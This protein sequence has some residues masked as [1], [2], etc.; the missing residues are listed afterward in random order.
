MNILAEIAEAL[1]IGI[2]LCADCFAVS[3]CASLGM[4]RQQLRSS[5]WKVAPSF[6]VIQSLLLV[7]GWLAAHLAGEWMAA[8]LAHYETIAHIIA[9]LL[10]LWIGLEMVIDSLRKEETTRLEL[11]SFKSII[12]GGIATSIDALAVGVTFAFLN[13]NIWTSILLIGVTTCV[14]SMIGVKVGSVFGAKYEKRAEI[15][16]GVILILL[17]VKILLEHLGVL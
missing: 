9:F 7:A 17:G 12:V 4:N 2:S 1:L 14:L 10:L 8:H 6:A 5:F 3:L 16:G 11:K 13:V 15:V